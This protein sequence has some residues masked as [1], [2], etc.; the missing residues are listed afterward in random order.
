MRAWFCIL[1]IALGLTGVVALT[2]GVHGGTS[3]VN[4][5]AAVSASVAYLQ[6][7]AS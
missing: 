3:G 1:T 2:E 4:D 6:A 5:A 7:R